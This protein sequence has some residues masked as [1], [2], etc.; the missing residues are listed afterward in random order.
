MIKLIICKHLSPELSLIPLFDLIPALFSASH[1]WSAVTAPVV[2]FVSWGFCVRSILLVSKVHM[3]TCLVKLMF[4]LGLQART[5]AE[6]SRCNSRHS[7]LTWCLM[8]QSSRENCG[9]IFSVWLLSLPAA[10]TRA[11]Q[12]SAV[13]QRAPLTRFLSEEPCASLRSV[14]LPTH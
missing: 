8:G 14:E 7:F 5:A 2:I 1:W 11:G 12:T 4:L 13:S 10:V 3:L 6:V 9:A